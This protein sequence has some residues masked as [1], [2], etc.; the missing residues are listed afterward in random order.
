MNFSND[1][2]SPRPEANAG[3]WRRRLTWLFTVAACAVLL[4]AA[5]WV[6]R[7]PILREAGR[8]WIV[9]DKPFHADA[10]VVLGGELQSRSMAAARLFSAGYADKVLVVSPTVKPSDKLG[11]TIPD[12]ELTRRL[13]IAQGVPAA[14]IF[15]LGHDVKNTRQEA[16]SLHEWADRNGGSRFLVVTGLFQSRRA[17]WIFRKELGGTD[18]IRVVPVVPLNYE[19]DKWWNDEQGVLEFQNEIVKYAWYRLKY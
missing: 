14:A 8:M 19:A 18:R 4:S 9:S 11:I 16:A 10:I 6:F 13:L 3:C 2:A 1:S 17:L 15:P 7:A 12:A 5:C